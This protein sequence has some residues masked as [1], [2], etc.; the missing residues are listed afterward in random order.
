MLPTK[1]ERK[2]KYHL[3]CETIVSYYEWMHI[4]N[5]ICLEIK[6][7]AK[8]L[9]FKIKGAS[10]SWVSCSICNILNTSTSSTNLSHVGGGGQ[11][12][13]ALLPWVS[14]KIDD[15]NLLLCIPYI[16]TLSE[17]IAKTTSTQS[18]NPQPNIKTYCTT[19]KLVKYSMEKSGVV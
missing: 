18:T 11:V 10:Q 4:N 15:L 2:Q 9:C 14:I 13:L 3:S 19:K 6:E 17:K 8:V 16:P 12:S 5:T 1:V 7:H